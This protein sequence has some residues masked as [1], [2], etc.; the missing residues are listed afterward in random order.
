[1]AVNP[2]VFGREPTTAFRERSFII[3]SPSVHTTPGSLWVPG[4]FRGQNSEFE[5][6]P[7]H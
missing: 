5:N 6:R 4:C 1:M 2:P 3:T 7:I